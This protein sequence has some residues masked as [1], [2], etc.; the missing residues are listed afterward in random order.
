MQPPLPLGV[1]RY[2]AIRCVFFRP[3]APSLPLVSIVGPATLLTA[4]SDI[5]GEIRDAR[6]GRDSDYG[7]KWSKPD[8]CIYSIICTSALS[9]LLSHEY[10]QGGLNQAAQNDATIHKA[11]LHTS[12]YC[13][14][15]NQMERI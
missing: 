1:G 2:V 9:F 4:V 8:L 7:G 6:N 11:T 14:H 15:F 12:C 5:R 3:S 10:T 13:A